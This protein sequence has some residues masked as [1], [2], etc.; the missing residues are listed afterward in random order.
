MNLEQICYSLP[1]AQAFIQSVADG[2]GNGVAIVI[3]PDNLSREMASRLIRD[4]LNAKNYRLQEL[5]SPGDA[6]P[7]SVSSVAMG[8]TWPSARTPR[9]LRNL[10]GCEGLPDLLLLRRIGQRSSRQWTEFIEGWAR[11]WKDSRESGDHA[12]SLC[13]IAKL[14]DF[15]F[16]LSWAGSGVD[17]HWW[18]GFPSVLEMK[19]ACRLAN[20]QD[21]DS[22]E[23]GRWREH[24]LPSLANNDVQLAEMMWDQVGKSP[25]QIVDGLADYWRTLE[26][27]DAICRIEELKEL[28]KADKRVYLIGRELPQNLR[29]AWAS[30][31]LVYS[32]E[33]GLA[34]HPA[35]LAY[36]DHRRDVEKILWRGEAEFLL[37]IL[38]D[39]RLRVCEE[40][41]NEYGNDWPVKWGEPATGYELEQVKLTPLAAE[42][43]HIDYVFRVFGDELQGKLYLS[44]LVGKVR[45]IRNKIAHYNPVPLQEYVDLC[46]E[47]DKIGL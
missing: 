34:V 39:I 46:E 40:L 12:P 38:N 25:D 27:P 20:Q 37:P 24:V 32:P 16:S 18:W 29:R 9:N 5:S 41:T 43:G 22:S 4:R 1:S 13:V 42:L 30:G 11:Q 44:R 15:D 19:L 6:D 35:L 47:R 10:F 45:N 26:E 31:A 17:F 7:V 33:Y 3:L 8:A 23:V 28:V 21:D 36:A 14:R 2:V